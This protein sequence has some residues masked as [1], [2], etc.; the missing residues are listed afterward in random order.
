MKVALPKSLLCLLLVTWSLPAGFASASGST[1]PQP[2]CLDKDKQSPV[3]G[4]HL[5]V[6]LRSEPK[7]LNPVFANDISSREVIGQMTADLIHI[8]RY[9]QLSESALGKSWKVSSDACRY[10]LEL[11][12]D[13]RF[14]DGT[15]V[16]ADDVLFS[17]KLYLDEGVNAPQ[18]D[19]LLV[20]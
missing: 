18:R 8:N 7:T 16:D 17:F 9:T 11:R 15:P 1:V 12:H 4:G 3:Y 10:T 14:S 13:L 5:V 2:A 6:A 20:G 19:S